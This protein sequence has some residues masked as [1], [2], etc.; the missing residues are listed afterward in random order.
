MIYVCLSLCKAGFV[1]E[2]KHTQIPNSVNISDFYY[3]K[4]LSILMWRKGYTNIAWNSVSGENG[5]FCRFSSNYS[6]QVSQ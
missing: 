1:G 6:T 4:K 3:S 2:N 5:R